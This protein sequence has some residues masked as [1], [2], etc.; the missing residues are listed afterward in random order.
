MTK[1]VH[2]FLLSDL[3]LRYFLVEL[4]ERRENLR[5]SGK[6]LKMKHGEKNTFQKQAT[7]YNELPDN[8]KKEN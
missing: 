4:A 6:E 1:L 7:I 3:W 5:S 2:Q 8:I